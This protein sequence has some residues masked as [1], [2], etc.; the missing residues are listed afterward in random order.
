MAV[1]GG[2][3]GQGSGP[4]FLNNMECAGDEKN[5]LQCKHSGIAL[6]QPSCRHAFDAGVVCA[7]KK[8]R[9]A[10]YILTICVILKLL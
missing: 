10:T 1:S 9:V 6:Q 7:G 2:G 5:L 3:F 4:I 8:L